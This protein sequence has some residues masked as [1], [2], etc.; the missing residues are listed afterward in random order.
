MFLHDQFNYVEKL[1]CLYAGTWGGVEY[2]QSLTISI[3]Y[4]CCFEIH[5]FK[6]VFICVQELLGSVPVGQMCR[7]VF[8]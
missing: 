3:K 6:L 2:T 4:A 7:I 5:V 8:L 1:L